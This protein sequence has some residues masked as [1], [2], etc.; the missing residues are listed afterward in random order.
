MC[1]QQKLFINVGNMFERV[2]L[3]VW[4]IMVVREVNLPLLQVK[5]YDETAAIV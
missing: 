2:W 4:P 1:E 3:V 5:G